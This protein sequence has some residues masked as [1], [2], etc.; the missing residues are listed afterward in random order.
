MLWL[1][2]L[3]VPSLLECV[4]LA[5]SKLIVVGLVSGSSFTLL[6]ECLVIVH[7]T[8]QIVIISHELVA[9]VG[10]VHIFEFV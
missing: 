8:P 10:S 9:D 6:L 3:G 4:A 5:G 7:W 2:L 1:L